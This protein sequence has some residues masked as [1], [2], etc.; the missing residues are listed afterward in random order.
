MTPQPQRRR[1]F[2]S[3]RDAETGTAQWSLNIEKTK[4]L[5]T[6]VG[7]LL[8]LAG[9]SATA[10]WLLLGPRVDAAVKAERAEH[11]GVHQREEKER[12]Q[13]AA[14]IAALTTELKA[15]QRE[16]AATRAELA[17]VQGYLEG[18]RP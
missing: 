16:L 8:T 2:S 3:Y 7:S 15:T 10:L 14:A 17:N 13:L 4:G 5:A 6:L 11:A 12:D 18:R 9:T 1:A